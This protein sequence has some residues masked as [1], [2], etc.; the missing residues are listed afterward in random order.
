MNI[1]IDIETVPIFREYD[2]IYAQMRELRDEKYTK[3]VR[4]WDYDR[5]EHWRWKAAFFP[6][7]GKI[8]CISLWLE[9]DDGTLR[10]TSLT[11]DEDEILA[12]FMTMMHKIKKDPV[13]VWHNI[14]NYDLPFITK[15][16]LKRNIP[17][18]PSLYSI[19]KKPREIQHQDTMLLYKFGGSTSTSLAV[20]CDH[21]G[22]HSPKDDIDGS[23]VA[24]V[25]YETW[26]IDRIARYCENDVIAT[27]A[28]YKRLMSC[29]WDETQAFE[30]LKNIQDRKLNTPLSQEADNSELENKI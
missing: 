4:W 29:T 2:K 15:R 6:E 16:A 14:I 25:F 7:F 12:T 10:T 30:T 11:G 8:V 21:L 20:I 1:Y 3:E 18:H 19:G 9:N 22:I 13:Y 26:D 24:K 28:L 27:H 5:D 17:L 23:E